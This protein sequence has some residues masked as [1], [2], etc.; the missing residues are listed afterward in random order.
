MKILLIVALAFSF[1]G[2]CFLLIKLGEIHIQPRAGKDVSVEMKNMLNQWEPMILVHGYNDNFSVAKYL[3]ELTE[4]DEI[5]RG[6]RAKGSFRAL[7][8]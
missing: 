4:N 8:H 7:V 1:A 3:V 2:N 5:A 6:G